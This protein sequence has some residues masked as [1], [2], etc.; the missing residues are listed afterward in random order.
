MHDIFVSYGHHSLVAFQNIMEAEVECDQS[1]NV[2]KKK[3]LSMVIQVCE[4]SIKIII[5]FDSLI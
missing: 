2:K 4:F 3:N 1:C 5:V